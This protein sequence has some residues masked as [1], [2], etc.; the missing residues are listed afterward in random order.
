MTEQVHYRAPKAL[1]LHLEQVEKR[2]R[3][4]GQRDEAERRREAEERQRE[5]ADGAA[6]LEA[7]VRSAAIKAQQR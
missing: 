5:H 7:A 4:D 1:R 2:I 6:A 3:Q